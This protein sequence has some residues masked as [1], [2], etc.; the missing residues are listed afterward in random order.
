MFV[1]VRGL[2][3]RPAV[4]DIVIDSETVTIA[5]KRSTGEHW[6]ISGRMVNF[7]TMEVVTV[8]VYGGYLGGFATATRVM[9]S[10]SEK[11]SITFAIGPEIDCPEMKMQILC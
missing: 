6:I 5:G 11:R 1:K 9:V 3:I 7:S 2:Q 10:T 8:V 4:R